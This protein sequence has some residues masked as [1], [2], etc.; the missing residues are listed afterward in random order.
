MDSTKGKP[1]TIVPPRSRGY[2]GYLVVLMTVVALM[3]WYISTIK[4]TALPYILKEYSLTPAQFSW[5][6]S[7]FLIPTFLVFLLNGLN[8]II[9]RKWSIFILILLMGSSCI[10][11]VYFT[12]SFLMFM[13][14]YAVAMLT[15]VSNM[16]VSY[17]HLTLPTKRIV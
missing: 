12:P 1:V 17:T 16:S 15:T 9:G 10:C 5:T 13:A 8:D 4:T 14:F 2:I 6:E 7:L 3:D 11:I